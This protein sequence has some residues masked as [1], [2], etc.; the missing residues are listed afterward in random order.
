M[1]AYPQKDQEIYSRGLTELITANDI[2]R[3]Y[4]YALDKVISQAKKFK[5]KSSFHTRT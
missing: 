5:T 4:E 3:H 1:R 2:K